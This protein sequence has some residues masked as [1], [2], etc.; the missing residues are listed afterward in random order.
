MSEIVKTIRSIIKYT[1]K[2]ISPPNGPTH[3]NPRLSTM[4]NN[5]FIP[6]VECQATET[7]AL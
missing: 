5:L 2:R 4:F 7:T 1:S 3:S 6:L